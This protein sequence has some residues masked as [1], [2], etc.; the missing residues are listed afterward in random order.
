MVLRQQQIPI[1]GYPDIW[2]VLL[3]YEHS[4]KQPAVM[5]GYRVEWQVG[6][7]AEKLF[8][9][10]IPFELVLFSGELRQ[11]LDQVCE[12]AGRRFRLE[13]W[14]KAGAP[15]QHGEQVQIRAKFP[16]PLPQAQVVL[17]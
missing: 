12:T 4:G 1:Y 15:L 17:F 11:V 8:G 9:K 13:R 6:R 7:L 14:L 5:T 3:E 10:S 2:Q 16:C